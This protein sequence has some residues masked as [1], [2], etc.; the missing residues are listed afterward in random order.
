[1]TRDEYKAEKTRLFRE[2]RE[3]SSDIDRRFADENSDVQIGD[4][5]GN[6]YRLIRV[7]RIQYYR[8]YDKTVREAFPACVY[9]GPRMQSK[10]VQFKRKSEAAVYQGEMD[11]HYRAKKG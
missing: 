4:I 2:S 8:R 1:M 11:I 3:K 9:C 5:V 7:E 6:N 10:W